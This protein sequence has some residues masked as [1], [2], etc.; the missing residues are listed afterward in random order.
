MGEESTPNSAAAN[1]NAMG[2]DD[3]NRG[4][5][6]SRMSY[7]AMQMKRDGNTS[8][9]AMPTASPAGRS[10]Y[11]ASLGQGASP[12][13]APPAYP[14]PEVSYM[15]PPPGMYVMPY[16]AYPGS[17]HPYGAYP[18]DQSQQLQQPPA[19]DSATE[20]ELPEGKD[21]RSQD[22]LKQEAE[23]GADTTAGDSS[24]PLDESPKPKRKKQGLRRLM[25]F[26]PK[27]CAGVT[28]G[29]LLAL[30]LI[31]FFTIPRAPNISISLLEVTGGP[32]VTYEREKLDYGLDIRANVTVM[33]KS[34]NFYPLT[35]NKITLEGYDADNLIKIGNGTVKNFHVRPQTNS[36]HNGT[37]SLSY[38]SSD[39]N[40]KI[41]NGLYSRCTPS[42]PPDG[43]N[44][45][46]VGNINIRMLADIEIDSIKWLG[47]H[48]KI[49]VNTEL[50]C[51][52]E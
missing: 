35:I 27:V 18:N 3:R 30:F 46:K 9:H 5:Q 26:A 16:A 36:Y 28:F 44:K 48:P 14:S 29:V 13:P 50:I 38:H 11:Y 23:S 33:A 39:Q 31:L 34:G 6:T 20:S 47:I 40:N 7:Y 49:A 51:P 19:E 10:S 12:Q 8:P 45:G 24:D 17:P 42:Y 52:D 43:P 22:R 25:C 37:F 41:L 32:Y 2:F 4:A 21:S 1:P 15:Y